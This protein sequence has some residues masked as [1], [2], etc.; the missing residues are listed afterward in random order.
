MII[1]QTIATKSGIVVVKEDT[2]LNKNL[3]KRIQDLEATGMIASH[4]VVL[5]QGQ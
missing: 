2:V 5:V 3:I 1:N 4:V